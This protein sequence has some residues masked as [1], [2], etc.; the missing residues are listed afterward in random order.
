MRKALVFLFVLLGFLAFTSSFAS[1]ERG[2][3]IIL[4]LPENEIITESKL[5]GSVEIIEDAA[6][7]GTALIKVELPD[8]VVS[9]GERAFADIS[10]LRE[11]RIPHST[12]QI[13][14]TAF[15]GS[16]RI[17]ITAPSN[18]YARTF[19]KNHGI[20]FSPIIMFCA[21]TQ[22]SSF[23]VF[24][25]NRSTKVVENDDESVCRPET[26]WR[27]IEELCITRTEEIIANHV[28]GRSPPIA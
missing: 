26:Q 4:E 15:E 7:E 28:Q 20:P 25:V 27:R 3:A 5:P 22:T 13:A 19:A 14:S 23:S 12:K 17:T 18:S 16:N 2:I 10:S 8:T 6:F 24:S 11:I 1:A 21:S 9:I